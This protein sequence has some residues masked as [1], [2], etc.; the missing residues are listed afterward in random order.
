MVIQIFSIDGL[1][2]FP[3]WGCQTTFFVLLSYRLAL[4]ICFNINGNGNTCFNS[5]ELP[6]GKYTKVE[7]KQEF[8]YANRYRY[9]VEINDDEV[10]TVTNTK[11]QEFVNPKLYIGD[12]FHQPAKCTIKNF[13]WVN[14]GKKIH[15]LRRK[16]FRD[17]CDFESYHESFVSRHF[18]TKLQ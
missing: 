16:K 8:K 1:M 3:Y 9:S 6:K 15:N 13:K 12:A 11:A 14:I 5:K 4:H 18:W 7:I 2:F 10:Y 17:S